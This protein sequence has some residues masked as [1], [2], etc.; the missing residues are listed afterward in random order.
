MQSLSFDSQ[1]I[2]IQIYHVEQF[3]CLKY[4][5]SGKNTVFPS[6]HFY[7]SMK[8][9]LKSYLLNVWEDLPLSARFVRGKYRSIQYC[10]YVMQHKMK[11][12][13]NWPEPAEKQQ[14][15]INVV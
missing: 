11:I 12:K 13:Q 14:E 8:H 7:N 9:F 15:F 1:H 5:I 6:W 10:F 2:F 4:M 3:T